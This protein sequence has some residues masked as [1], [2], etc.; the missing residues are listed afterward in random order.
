MILESLT[1]APASRWKEEKRHGQVAEGFAADLVML[2]ADPFADV[3]NFA[4]VQCVLRAGA[5]IYSRA[6][7]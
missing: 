2:A 7:P 6:R 5:P 1:T 4:N 3:K